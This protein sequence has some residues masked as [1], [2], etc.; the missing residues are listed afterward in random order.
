MDNCQSKLQQAGKES[1]S[2][3]VYFKHF[4]KIFASHF[5]P[6]DLDVNKLGVKALMNKERYNVL[7]KMLSEDAS[8]KELLDFLDEHGE[9]QVDNFVI[10]F[11]SSLK[12]T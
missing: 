8:P 10:L 4:I 9:F 11:C 6:L 7:K 2:G 12:M 5:E 1:D 3:L